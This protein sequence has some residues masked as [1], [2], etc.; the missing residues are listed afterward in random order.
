MSLLLLAGGVALIAFGG[1]GLPS[2]PLSRA[3][4]TG[5][6]NRPPVGGWQT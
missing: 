6:G 1:A 4:P 3:E 2:Q 5:S